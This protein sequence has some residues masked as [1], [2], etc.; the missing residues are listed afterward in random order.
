MRHES[1]GRTCVCGVVERSRWV[2]SWG[3]AKAR[4][5]KKR[6]VWFWR[7]WGREQAESSQKIFSKEFFLE[8]ELFFG[9]GFRSGRFGGGMT[10]VSVLVIFLC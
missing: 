1:W 9:H 4:R 7:R 10:R 8:N 6:I 3:A 5:I 2:S